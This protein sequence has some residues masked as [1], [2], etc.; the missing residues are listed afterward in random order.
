MAAWKGK[1][2]RAGAAVKQARALGE[3]EEAIDAL[4]AEVAKFEKSVPAHEKM[5]SRAEQALENQKREEEDYLIR[6]KK[7][8]FWE[9]N[10]FLVHGENINQD[11]REEIARKVEMFKII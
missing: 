7:V 3:P 10:S 2:K 11:E 9:P 4:L 8:H 6:R 1:T 5:V